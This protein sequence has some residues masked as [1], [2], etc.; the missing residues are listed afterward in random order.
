MSNCAPEVQRNLGPASDEDYGHWLADSFLPHH[1]SLGLSS[2]VPVTILTV[3]WEQIGLAWSM[4]I[5]LNLFE[6]WTFGDPI[7]YE[8]LK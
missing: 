6:I 3:T 1:S 8:Q 2:A 4:A 5:H 7:V